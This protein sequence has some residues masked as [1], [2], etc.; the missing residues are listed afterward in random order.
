MPT[1]NPY[2]RNDPPSPPRTTLDR[3]HNLIR[4][5][6]CPPFFSSLHYAR[7]LS[8]KYFPHL[9]SNL[10]AVVDKGG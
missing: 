4:L 6:Q 7:A 3:I 10:F 9:H 8:L 5:S 1:H 2:P